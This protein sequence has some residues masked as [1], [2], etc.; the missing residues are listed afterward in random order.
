MIPRTSSGLIKFRPVRKG[1]RVAL[2]APASPFDR[3]EFDRGVEEIRRLG[4]EPVWDEDVFERQAITAGSPRVR[5]AALLRALDKLNADAVISVRGGYG[6]VELLPLLDT[7]RVRNA[8]T[9]FVG[10]SDVTSLHSYLGTVVGLASVHGAMLEGRLAAGPDA[11]DPVSWLKSMSAE[12]LGEMAPE[13]FEVLS[14]GF[15]G[16]A[17]GPLVGGTLTQLLAS[18][19]TAYEFNP[20]AGHVLFLDE[21]NERPYRLHRMLTQ[22]RLSG[23]LQRAAAVVFGQLPGCD[24]PG[25]KITARDVIK[26]VLLQGFQGPVLFGFPS[27][28]S[29]SPSISVPFGVQVRVVGNP[30]QPV[31]V[32]EEAAAAD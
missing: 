19:G 7:E 15:P 11:Y 12:P 32:F 27:G 26:D 13:G 29:S 2:V 23:R 18:F 1:S 30:H 6:S 22:L 28:H 16:V 20:P 4:L 9:A 3:A 10:Y 25:G 21:V 17:S 31:V 5:V 14:P 8:R 24:E